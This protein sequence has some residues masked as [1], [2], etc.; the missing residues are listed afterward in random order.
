MLD[1]AESA[2]LL[3]NHVLGDSARQARDIDIA[4]VGQTDDTVVARL[5][6]EGVLKRLLVIRELLV[7]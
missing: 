6:V 7:I 5:L 2:E 4:V 1:G 3:A